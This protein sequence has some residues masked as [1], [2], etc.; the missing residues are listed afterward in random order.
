MIAQLKESKDPLIRKFKESEL[1]PIINDTVY[2][3][4]ELSETDEDVSA[5]KRKLVLKDLEWR[6]TTVSLLNIKE[7]NYLYI[8]N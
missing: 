8:T 7:Y 1:L 4:P 2:H 5:T 3:S 6:S